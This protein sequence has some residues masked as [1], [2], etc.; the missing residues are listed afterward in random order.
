MYPDQIQDLYNLAV[1]ANNAVL[2]K[3]AAIG[4]GGQ[5]VVP[6]APYQN[7]AGLYD[8]PMEMAGYSALSEARAQINAQTILDGQPVG[9]NWLPYQQGLN[10]N[11]QAV[12]AGMGMQQNPKTASAEEVNYHFQKMASSGLFPNPQLL[13]D[14]AGWEAIDMTARQKAASATEA[15]IANMI[16]SGVL[17]QVRPDFLPV[18]LSQSETV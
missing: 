9:T 1:A 10:E 15:Q 11:Y 13:P 17:Q 6:T 2:S 5:Q 16:N 3:S 12:Q 7:A 18:L 8:P 4:V 14:M